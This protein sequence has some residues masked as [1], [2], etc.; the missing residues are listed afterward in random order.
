MAPCRLPGC[1]DIDRDHRL[2]ALPERLARERSRRAIAAQIGDDDPVAR[3]RQ[4]RGDIK[5][6]VDV[7]GPVVQQK[8]Y[9]A[10]GGARLGVSAASIC[11]RGANAVF[12]PGLI[13]GRFSFVAP[14]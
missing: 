2:L 11:F 12:V 10:I 4:Q 14:V 1:D 7:V 9:R 3:R 5:K 6:A 13:A 8:D